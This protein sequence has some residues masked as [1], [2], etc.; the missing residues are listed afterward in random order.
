ML[1]LPFWLCSGAFC[2]LSL[3][4]YEDVCVKPPSFRMSFGFQVCFSFRCVHFTS[5]GYWLSNQ[6]IY[7]SFLPPLWRSLICRSP[8]IKSIRCPIIGFCF[9]L[10]VHRYGGVFHSSA[11]PISFR[12]PIIIFP[13]PANRCGRVGAVVFR[14]CGRL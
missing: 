1:W 14:R 9:A 13:R 8:I 4:R 6:R 2:H 7:R 10:P 11:D 12:H 3:R 5:V